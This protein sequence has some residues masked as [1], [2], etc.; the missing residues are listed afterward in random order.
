MLAPYIIVTG[1][2]IEGFEYIGPFPSADEAAAYGNTDPHL[3]DGDWWTAPLYTP[4]E[5]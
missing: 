4:A 5:E 1:N 2:P 3:P